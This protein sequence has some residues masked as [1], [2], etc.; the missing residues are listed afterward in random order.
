MYEPVS[1]IH[2]AA[3]VHLANNAGRVAGL[4][5]RVALHSEDAGSDLEYE[6]EIL[7]NE[8]RELLELPDWLSDQVDFTAI[9]RHAMAHYY[10]TRPGRFW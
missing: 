4:A 8:L 3:L 9:A 1:E 10:R 5:L 7:A 2:F 6:V